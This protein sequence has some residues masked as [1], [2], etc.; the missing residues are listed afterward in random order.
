MQRNALQDDHQIDRLI[1]ERHHW[2][3]LPNCGK[4]DNF[5]LNKNDWNLTDEKTRYEYVGHMLQDPFPELRTKLISVY[6]FIKER[7]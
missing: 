7:V 1:D 2:R 6:D 5:R 3:I 4:E